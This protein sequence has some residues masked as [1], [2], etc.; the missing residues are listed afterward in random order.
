MFCDVMEFQCY[1][2]IIID[3]HMLTIGNVELLRYTVEPPIK[4]YFGNNI[5][6]AVLSLIERL[7]NY[8]EW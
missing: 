7:R 2:K 6:S 3:L 1:C 8:R 5:N 4:G